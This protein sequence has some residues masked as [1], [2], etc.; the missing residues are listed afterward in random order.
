MGRLQVRPGVL[1]EPLGA[2]WA[3]F[4]PAN[5]QTLL[6]NTEAAAFLEV[7]LEMPRSIAEIDAVMSADGGVP[8]GSITS[9]L[10]DTAVDLEATGLILSE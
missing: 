6:L 3:C 2:V 9:I 7:L 10:E 5:G 1:L 4:S 8:L